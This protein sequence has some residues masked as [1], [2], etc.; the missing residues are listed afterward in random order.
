MIDRF[1]GD[2]FV[3]LSCPLWSNVL[4]SDAR[5]PIYTF[6]T[7]PCSKRCRFSTWGVFECDF[8]HRRSVPTL[9]MLYKIRC[10][11]IHHL[12][13][14]LPVPYV[15]VQVTRG[16]LVA[17]RYMLMS[18]LEEEPRSITGPLVSSQCLFGMMLLALYTMMWD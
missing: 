15:P 1:L 4:R 12:N 11:P 9:C 14:A 13:G 16:A 17:H 6:N 7:G 3:V 5:L 2:T 18:L 10:N 8:A